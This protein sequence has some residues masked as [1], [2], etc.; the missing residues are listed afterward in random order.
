MSAPVSTIALESDITCPTCGFLKQEVMPTEACQF[1]YE[2][3]GCKTL[4]RPKTGDC[5]V[6]CSFGSV[7]C[8]PIALAGL[9]NQ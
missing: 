6:F 3:Q 7:P 9:L 8:P 1:F 5:C 4:L 2:C